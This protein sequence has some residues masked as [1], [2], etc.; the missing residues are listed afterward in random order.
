M[1]RVGG[2]P[3]ATRRRRA[4]RAG[5]RCRRCRLVRRGSAGVDV[6]VEEQLD[7]GE[8]RRR[9]RPASVD[10]D[11]ATVDQKSWRAAGR[12]RPV[13]R[14]RPMTSAEP[15][16][17]D[18]VGR[19]DVTESGDRCRRTAGSS[20]ASVA[21][22]RS[23]STPG[24]PGTRPQRLDE[25]LR[26]ADVG[27][28]RSA[29]SMLP[30]TP[31]GARSAH[32]RVRWASIPANS[33]VADLGAQGVHRG[34]GWAATQCPGGVVPKVCAVVVERA[35]QPVWPAAWRSAPRPCTAAMATTWSA[36]S[37]SARVSR[38]PTRGRRA[39]RRRA[40]CPSGGAPRRRSGPSR[41]HP[42]REER[43]L[44]SRV[45]TWRPPS[46]GEAGGPGWWWAAHGAATR[47][48]PAQL[49][50]HKPSTP[51]SGHRTSRLVH[52]SSVLRVAPPRGEP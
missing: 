41:R 45:A 51:P 26:A 13:V 3:R 22:S 6:G 40:G 37:A 8:A 36:G 32:S 11:R 33:S 1:V 7:D 31:A 34:G 27:C 18:V 29:R 50:C 21:R 9:G 24:R 47:W 49:L 28:R 25:P 19:D 46:R 15:D 44:S 39:R 38:A 5:S 43:P 48:A 35:D 23:G 14:I 12:R 17:V 2:R 30:R 42:G 52:H 4:G 16:V 20:A 10:D